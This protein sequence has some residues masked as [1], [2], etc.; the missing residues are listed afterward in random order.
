MQIMGT[1]VLDVF[2]GHLARRQFFSGQGAAHG[3]C[4]G[5]GEGQ[6]DP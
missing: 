3:A 6:S 5:H 2:K 4:Q 1:L